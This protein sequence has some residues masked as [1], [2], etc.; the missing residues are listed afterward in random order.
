MLSIDLRDVHKSF[1]IPHEQHTTLTERMLS[2]FRTVSYE[3]LEAL[4]GIDLQLEEGS[5]TGIIGG[6]GS[7]KSTLLKIISGLLLPDRGSVQIHGTMSALLELGLGFS[8]ELTVQEN[9]ELYAAVLGYP[10]REVKARVN[11]AIDFAELERFRDAKLKN[12]S[13]GMRARLGFSTALQAESDIMLLDEILA[14]GDASFQRKCLDVFEDFKRRRRTIILVT[15]NLGQVQQFC[16]DAVL[17][18]DGVIAERGDPDTVIKRYLSTVNPD[19]LAM[20]ALSASN[21]KRLG[22]GRIRVIG[23]WLESSGER[24]ERIR[25]REHAVLVVRYRVFA[26]TDRPTIGFALDAENGVTVYSIN[27]IWTGEST[28]P[29]YAG[30]II[31]M[32]VP[33][34]VGLANGRY[35]ARAG[36]ASYDGNVFHDLHNGVVK[37]VVHG[38][39]NRDGPAD[40]GGEITYR[41]MSDE[42]TE[43][44]INPSRKSAK[45]GV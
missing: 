25:S 41:M 33:F 30:Q 22:D 1:R 21:E 13:T 23:G 16:D 32:R 2:L 7:G 29:V 26:D 24:V 6:N 37:F 35:T 28:E 40:L 3:R 36:V 8:P 11:G 19:A 42:E 27:S 17:L 18:E 34:H 20:A 10:R 39:L 15:H 45:G 38:S 9:V 4:R 12:L 14:V 43:M 5:F 31:E 44:P